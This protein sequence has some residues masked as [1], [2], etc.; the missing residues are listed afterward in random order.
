MKLVPVT[1]ENA[2]G[3]LYRAQRVLQGLD[4]PVCLS[5]RR[6][7]RDLLE[8]LFSLVRDEIPLTEEEQLDLALF[9]WRSAGGRVDAAL[10]QRIKRAILNVA[11][12]RV[13]SGLALAR[14]SPRKPA[15]A[16]EPAA[17]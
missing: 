6:I 3:Y 7:A 5:E 16:C 14:R 4:E 1:P 13:F 10:R 8:G 9:E 15:P 12:A 11:V 17:A 2:E